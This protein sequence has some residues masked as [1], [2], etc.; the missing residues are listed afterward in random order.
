MKQIQFLCM[1][2]S[3]NSTLQGQLECHA[4]KSHVH[5]NFCGE[6]NI[7][8]IMYGVRKFVLT[9]KKYNFYLKSIIS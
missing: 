1:P 9:Y 5:M 3:Q 6:G 8:I 2:I 4:G 7:K